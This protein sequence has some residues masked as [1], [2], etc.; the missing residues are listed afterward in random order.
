MSPDIE[1]WYSRYKKQ[2]EGSGEPPA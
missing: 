1:A 2:K